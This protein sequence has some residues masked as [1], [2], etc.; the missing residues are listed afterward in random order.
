MFR[1]NQEK[2]QEKLEKKLSRVGTTGWYIGTYA[3]NLAKIA[4]VAYAVN[5][6]VQTARLLASD[7]YQSRQE[8]VQH[9]YN[10]VDD[11]RKDSILHTGIQTYVRTK[12]TINPE[13]RIDIEEFEKHIDIASDTKEE[14]DY[15]I[16][17]IYN[18]LV[19]F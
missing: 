11:L 16:K 6:K 2:H 9:G 7:A 8:V 4:F 5:A 3:K 13:L 15:A 17:R 14:F 19:M 18:P 12:A 1:I 10:I